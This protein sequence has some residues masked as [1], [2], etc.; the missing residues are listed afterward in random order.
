MAQKVVIGVAQVLQHLKDGMT[1]EDIAE[2]YG[3]TMA[4]CKRL[5]QDSRLKGKKTIKKPSYVLVDDEEASVEENTVEDTTEIE[6][7]DEEVVETKEDFSVTTTDEVEEEQEEE[8]A[9][10]PEPAKATWD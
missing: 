3:I 9:V 5:F 6:V 10:A 1:R 8:V 2:H 7:K 4:E